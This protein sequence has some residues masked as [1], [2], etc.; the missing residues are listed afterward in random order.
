MTI[1]NYEDF[2]S[3]ELAFEGAFYYPPFGGAIFIPVESVVRSDLQAIT[4]LATESI[5]ITTWRAYI[6][7][8]S[9]DTSVVQQFPGALPRY[10]LGSYTLSNLGAYY[11]ITFLQY[12][13]QITENCS[14]IFGS[15]DPPTNVPY[16]TPT[17]NSA[18]AKI[19]G[20][21]LPGQPYPFNYATEFVLDPSTGVEFDLL[22]TYNGFYLPDVLPSTLDTLVI[23][24]S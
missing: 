8:S 16:F 14:F 13:E 4:T 22:V 15:P 21:F 18:L 24:N 10:K 3:G 6:R 5:C 23:Y 12:V 1:A 20:V 2:G 19:Y 7:A 9:I 17:L 11:P